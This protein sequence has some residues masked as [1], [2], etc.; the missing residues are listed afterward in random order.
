MPR[1]TLRAWLVAAPST[2][3]AALRFPTA[4]GLL[5]GTN[6]YRLRTLLTSARI[7]RMAAH[8]PHDSTSI[9]DDGRTSTHPYRRTVPANS[10]R[11]PT[12]SPELRSWAVSVVSGSPKRGSFRIPSSLLL[13]SFYLDQHR[14]ASP[15]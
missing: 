2:C 9:V 13:V 14:L 6:Y 1:C 12:R 8:R 5:C 7:C 3:S 10:C 11:T 15:G 4:H